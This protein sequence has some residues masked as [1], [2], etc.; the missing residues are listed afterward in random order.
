[1][2]WGKRKQEQ[3]SET[4]TAIALSVLDEPT[5]TDHRP[6]T[7]TTECCFGRTVHIKGD[8]HARED[9]R[10]EGT[11]EGNVCVEEHCVAIGESGRIQAD[12]RARSV[13]VEGQVIGNISAEDRVEVGA[14]GS[15]LGD[16][17]AGRVVLAEGARFK[18]S[19]DMG[20]V[21][22]GVEEAVAAVAAAKAA[23]DPA[24]SSL[25]GGDTSHT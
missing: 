9:I 5:A 15:V 6:A 11:V 16:I 8:L 19:I 1:M 14:T 18:G 4:T 22:S 24:L 17:R 7:T 25:F 3:T 2:G 10:I 13:T 12:V 20:T 23:I 21:P